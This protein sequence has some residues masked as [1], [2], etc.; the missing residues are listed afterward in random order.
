MWFARHA[1]HFLAALR[2]RY[3]LPS[4]CGSNLG[5][6]AL[7]QAHAHRIFGE[8]RLSSERAKIRSGRKGSAL[9]LTWNGTISGLGAYLDFQRRQG[10]NLAW[11]MTNKAQCISMLII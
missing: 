7:R 1:Q 2:Y 9:A 10:A 5:V 4:H 8:R 11:A 6:V 3:C